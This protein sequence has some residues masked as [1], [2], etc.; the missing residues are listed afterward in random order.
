MRE[1]G[2]YACWWQLIVGEKG[3]RAM[4]SEPCVGKCADCVG[5]DNDL[6]WKKLDIKVCDYN[7]IINE[8][9]AFTMC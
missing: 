1:C 8:L 5:E 2:E 9:I 6:K 4:W 7:Q 3:K